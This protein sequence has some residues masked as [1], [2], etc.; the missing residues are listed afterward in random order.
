MRG[1][2]YSPEDAVEAFKTHVLEMSQSEWKKCFD[3]FGLNARKSVQ[4]MLEI[5]FKN[6]KTI[7]D[8]KY[9]NFHY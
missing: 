8:D 1:L 7:F 5:T 2:R 9:S 6:N 3:K 4:N